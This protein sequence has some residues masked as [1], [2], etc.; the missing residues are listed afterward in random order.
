MASAET[1]RTSKTPLRSQPEVVGLGGRGRGGK[2]RQRNDGGRGG[3]VGVPPGQRGR[4][5][6]NS[7]WHGNEIVRLLK[8][9]FRLGSWTDGIGLMSPQDCMWL[10]VLRS[11]FRA[12][13]SMG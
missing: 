3:C 5:F 1:R 2:R 4:G 9:G 7:V 11:R 10:K 12:S 6:N 8:V 13:Y